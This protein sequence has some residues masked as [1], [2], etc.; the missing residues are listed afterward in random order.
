MFRER[1]KEEERKGEKP[2]SVTA[3]HAPSPQGPARNPG[4]CPDQESGQRPFGL[5][6]TFS[7]LNHTSHGLTIIFK[8]KVLPCSQRR[9][10]NNRMLVPKAKKRKRK[11]AQ[12]YTLCGSFPPCLTEHVEPDPNPCGDTGAPAA[13]GA[14]WI[15]FF[16]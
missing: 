14:M 9:R 11:S 15:A 4:L 16:H 1:G 5:Q 2:P 8:Y 13:G 6:A 10:E 12:M 3:V 7:P